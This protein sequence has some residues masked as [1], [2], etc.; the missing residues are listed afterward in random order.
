MTT[1][2]NLKYVLVNFISSFYRQRS[3]NFPNHKF[4]KQEPSYSVDRLL[5]RAKH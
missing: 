5:M 4:L 3:N 2:L 1:T